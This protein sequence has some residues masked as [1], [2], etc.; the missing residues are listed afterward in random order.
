MGTMRRTALTCLRA[1][2]PENTSAA[3]AL[4][5]FTYY[6]QSTT[7]EVGD[8]LLLPCLYLQLSRPFAPSTTHTIIQ[9]TNKPT[10]HDCGYHPPFPPWIR[11]SCSLP[12]LN[13]RPTSQNRPYPPPPTRLRR[14][15]LP[16]LLPPPPPPLLL[17]LSHNRIHPRPRQNRQLLQH[18]RP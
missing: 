12:N 2:W 17:R 9:T 7:Q 14:P 18:L 13:L 15:A 8:Y 3:T 1:G 10:S 6:R 4:V 5:G 16:L 11:H